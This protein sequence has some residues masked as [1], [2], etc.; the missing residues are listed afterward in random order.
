M[1]AIIAFRDPEARYGACPHCGGNTGYVTISR[2]YILTCTTHG[3]YWI[4]PTTP[5]WLRPDD[6]LAGW[7]ASCASLV[8]MRLVAPVYP[9]AAEPRSQA[10]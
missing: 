4:A 2:L 7:V 8:G 10:A 5:E 1:S 9:I 3:V 6:S